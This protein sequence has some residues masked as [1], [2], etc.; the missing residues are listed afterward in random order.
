MRLPNASDLISV[1]E[2]KKSA[3][4]QSSRSAV[5]FGFFAILAYVGGEV[6]IGS[7]LVKFL[8]EPDIGDLSP[9][10]AGKYAVIYWSGMM[11]GRFFGAYMMRR[12]RTASLLALHG[13]G[14]LLLVLVAATSSGV[15]AM[16]AILLV[17][18]SNSIMF[19]SI[20]SLAMERI[21]PS[22]NKAAG[23][24]TMGNI[25][26]ALVPIMQGLIA[27]QFGLHASFF[28][29]VICYVYIF[30]FA[31]SFARVPVGTHQPA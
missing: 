17:G 20:F 7:F 9:V 31:M 5:V 3:P 28:L 27:D 13:L 4:E 2:R 8:Q 1:F 14:G 12:I 16:T 6:A 11:V 18:F 22:N 25:G 29:P 10:M 21:G 23:I 26:G 30:M 24:L 19:P 15:V